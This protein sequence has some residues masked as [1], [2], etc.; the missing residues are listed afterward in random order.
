MLHFIGSGSAFNTKLG[1]NS[2]FYKE[3]DSLFI[4]DCGSSTFKQILDLNLLEGVERVHVY[5]SHTHPDHF[6][7]LGDFIFYLYY[8]IFGQEIKVS[9]YHHPK[10][11]VVSLL[12]GM[13]VTTELYNSYPVTTE[14]PA[15]FISNMDIIFNLVKS[16]HVQEIECYGLELLI[17]NASMYYSADSNEIPEN[18][19][20]NLIDG[21]YDYFFQDTCSIDYDGNVHLSLSKLYSTIPTE[22]RNVIYCM[23]LDK[24]FNVDTAKQL[25][26]NVV[27]NYK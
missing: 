26:F 19:L 17:G 18:V 24:S 8:V 21:K 22:Y 4:I 13:G 20:N 16:S 2:C 25:G 12:T 15:V 1:N 23:H 14:D 7:S 27:E 9:I 10:V 6:G 5:I 11:Q 3:N